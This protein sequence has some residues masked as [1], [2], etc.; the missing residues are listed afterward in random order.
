MKSDRIL[1][2]QLKRIGDLILTAPALADLRRA[3]PEA[4]V[5]L[6]TGPRLRDL[7]QCLP[8]VDQVIEYR[9][10]LGSAAAWTQ[11]LWGDWEAVLDFSGTDRSA[12]M[13]ALTR[14]PLRIGYRKFSG[15]GLRRRAYTRLSQASVRDLHTVDFHRALVAEAVGEPSGQGGDEPLLR[16]PE[17][18]VVAASEK[19]RAA[20][21]EG[22]F[23]V[24]HPGTARREKFWPV[25]RWVT[26]A[27]AVVEA[28]LQ[29]VLTGTGSGLEEEDVRQLRQQTEVPVVDL[30]SRLTLPELAALIRQADLA[31]GVDS[32]AMHLA[33][34]WRRPQVVL[35]GPTNPFHWRPRHESAR[36]VTAVQSGGQQTFHARDKGA[37][38]NLISTDAVLSAIQSLRLA[39]R[40]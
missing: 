2:L 40:L 7:G 37:D 13:T 9:A 19:A 5:V 32:M 3:R 25:E 20:G 28:G 22:A 24:I 18:V 27:R 12:L 36:V 35:F 26:V 14:A 39:G 29:V 10:P 6:V 1:V 38:M 21:L 16:L 8:G 15:G 33:A 31:L 4:E 34:L 23:A 11:A 30:T 17:T